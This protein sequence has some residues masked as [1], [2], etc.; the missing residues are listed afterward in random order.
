MRLRWQTI[1]TKQFF[2][3][4]GVKGE[5]G[6]SPEKKSYSAVHF[7]GEN[8]KGKRLKFATFFRS[9][10]S[11][12]PS[13]ELISSTK[14]N[15][16]SRRNSVR[17]VHPRQTERKKKKKNV[18]PR[19]LANE[20][21]PLSLHLCLIVSSICKSTVHTLTGP[22]FLTLER[23]K[24]S[25]EDVTSSKSRADVMF[26]LLFSLF[27]AAQSSVPPSFPLPPPLSLKS[28]KVGS[29]CR[30]HPLLRAPDI[31]PHKQ[32]TR[33]RLSQNSV[34]GVNEWRRINKDE[35]E[36]KKGKV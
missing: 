17:H 2:S 33:R 5:F 12:F 6:V 14:Q 35:T 16:S 19:I 27:S 10:L 8:E 34:T 26:S 9:P 29:S 28:V 13:Q 15:C 4:L 25:G 18:G 23:K 24:I 32:K 31:F 11:F 1:S 7:W 36:E 3:S 22:L 20:P 21:F 30:Q